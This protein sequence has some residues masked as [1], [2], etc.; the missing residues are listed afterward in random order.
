MSFVDKL[1]RW[2][3]RPQVA[4]ALLLLA[5]VGLAVGSF[6]PQRPTDD[7]AARARWEEAARARYGA[8][9]SPLDWLGLFRW[10]TSPL[11]WIALVL[12]VLATVLCTLNRWPGLWPRLLRRSAPQWGTLLTHL[13]V[14][15][16]LLA[17]ALSG[18]GWQEEMTLTA[19]ATGTFLT[20]GLA[21]RCDAVTLERYPDGSVA[22]YRVEITVLEDGREVR[23]GTVRPNAP[24]SLGKAAVF[25]S[26]Y[27]V[28]QGRPVVI[29]R[30][31]HDPGYVPFLIGGGLFLLGLVLRWTVGDGQR[32]TEDPV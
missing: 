25:L 13:T 7:P 10:Y 4:A 15:L 20:T 3:G 32:R 27:A 22:D 8:W 12:P 29:L 14:P 19:G 11:L 5:L 6:F 24:L 18:L 16:F 28:Q 21:L 31:V 30:A 2:F 23:R 26:G 9:M 17:L 1:L